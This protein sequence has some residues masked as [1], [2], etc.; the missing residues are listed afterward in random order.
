[1]S[2][3]VEIG[4]MGVTGAISPIKAGKLKALGVSSL[5]RSPVLPNVAAIA[6]TLPGFEAVTTMGVYAP[7]GTPPDIVARLNAELQ[8]A[9]AQPDVRERFADAGVE[10]SASSPDELGAILKN[11]IVKWAKVIKDA[12]I[13]VE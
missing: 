6:E 13:R 5:Q 8:K 4:F 11:E 7:A 12:G 9:V 10:A 3:E 1:M 2:G